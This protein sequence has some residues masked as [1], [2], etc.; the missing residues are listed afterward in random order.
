M[1]GEPDPFA[2][3]VE[4]LDDV[5]PEDAAAET[6]V[7]I[8]RRNAHAAW[9]LCEYAHEIE[10]GVQDSLIFEALDAAI[11]ANTKQLIDDISTTQ[12]ILG[13]FDHSAAL[14]TILARMYGEDNYPVI[15]PLNSRTAALTLVATQR[16]ILLPQQP[17]G[18]LAQVLADYH[19]ALEEKAIQARKTYFHASVDPDQHFGAISA[20]IVEATIAEFRARIPTSD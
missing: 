14:P 1:T 17:H 5:A 2:L 10:R 8:F 19:Q 3:I 12:R 15:A 13:S 16:S 18:H 11:S 9:K 6:L 7:P 4:S 20:D